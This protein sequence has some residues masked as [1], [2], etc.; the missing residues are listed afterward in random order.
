MSRRLVAIRI[1]ARPGYQR[2]KQ[3]VTNGK[4]DAHEGIDFYRPVAQPEKGRPLWGENQWPS[5]EMVPGFR[6]TYEAWVEKMKRLGL[7]VVRAIPERGSHAHTC[8]RWRRACPYSSLCDL[9]EA[10]PLRHLSMAVGLGLT[11]EEWL[12]LRSKVDDSFWVL[13]V[14]GTS[15][16]SSGWPSRE[17]N[18]RRLSATPE[19]PRWLQLWV[20]C[21]IKP[22][23]NR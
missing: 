10:A 20:C 12:D 7:I 23:T 3:N 8:S 22:Q 13:R 6:A 14:I 5:D 1:H 19:R 17:S 11:A 2:L 4:A 21:N 16:S 18:E 15:V 9:A